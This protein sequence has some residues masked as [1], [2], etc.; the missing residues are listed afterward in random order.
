MCEIRAITGTHTH[1]LSYTNTMNN[2]LSAK[3]GGVIQRFVILCQV[4]KQRHKIRILFFLTLSLFGASFLMYR[5]W[6]KRLFERSP[7][8]EKI[9]LT[10]LNDSM[11]GEN[12]KRREGHHNSYEYT[13]IEWSAVEDH[14]NW[15]GIKCNDSGHVEKILLF[16]FGLSGMI[17]WS[18]PCFYINYLTNLLNYV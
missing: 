1:R 18:Y 14:C 9:L 4:V 10:K 7:A 3:K 17:F 6:Q 5:E 15:Y 2:L 13:K 12:W 16:G 11:G 8:F